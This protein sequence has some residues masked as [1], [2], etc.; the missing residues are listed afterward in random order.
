M[1]QRR[2]EET[3]RRLLDTA[4]TAFTEG[5]FT[6][7]GVT[8]RSGVS[9]GSL[10]HHFGSFDGL[11]AAL[12]TECMALLLDALIDALERTRTPRTGVRAIVRAYLAFAGTNPARARFIH[13]APN[14]AGH[15]AAIA[16]R[17]APQIDR[18]VAWLRPHIAAGTVADLPIPLIEMLLIGPLAE[19]TRRWLAGVPG[20]DLAEAARVLP[21]PIWR[22]LQAGY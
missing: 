6:L 21:E 17:K 9:V 5:D 14:T 16:E 8:T 10:Y 2:S 19:V 12:Y 18:L 7:R 4:L 15:A 13:A 1:R 11:A 3:V 20:I 22:S